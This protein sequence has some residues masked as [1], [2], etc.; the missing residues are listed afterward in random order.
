M[1]LQG[2]MGNEA[3]KVHV[4]TMQ[5]TKQCSRCMQPAHSHPG[6]VHI[7]GVI[8]NTLTGMGADLSIK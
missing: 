3:G 6:T 5:E 2:V 8:I 1:L 4:F 7:T